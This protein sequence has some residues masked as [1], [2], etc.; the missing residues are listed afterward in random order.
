VSLWSARNPHEIRLNGLLMLKTSV[1]I[2]TEKWGGSHN[3]G[4][5]LELV[6]LTGHFKITGCEGVC[7]NRADSLLLFAPTKAAVATW[8]R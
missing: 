1:S 4:L 3:R 7:N 2:G 8:C 5:T 6:Q